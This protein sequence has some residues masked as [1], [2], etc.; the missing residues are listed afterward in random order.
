MTITPGNGGERSKYAVTK[1]ILTQRDLMCA[2]M[3]GVTEPCHLIA[4]N[5]DRAYEYT[6]KQNL[7]AV[8]TDGSAVLTLGDIGPLAAKPMMEGKSVLFKRFADID[9]FDLELDTQNPE[10]F[11]WAVRLL[12][13]TFGGICLEDIVSPK[14]FF[15]EEELRN[16][17]R[18]PVFHDKQHGAATVCVAALL[19][20]LELQRKKVEDIRL[21]IA[22]TGP[23]GMG[24]ANLLLE[25]GVRLENVLMIDDRGVLYEGRDGEMNPYEARFARKTEARTLADAMEG[26]DVLVGC[27]VGGAGDPEDGCLHGG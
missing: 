10:E 21:V 12:E 3:P 11:I 4:E 25:L 8:I 22:G 18:I 23:S 7:V 24:C 19:N 20:A 1:P 16:Q 27:S 6:A 26:A 17:M 5:P 9:A 15:I 14:C 2:Y 13:P